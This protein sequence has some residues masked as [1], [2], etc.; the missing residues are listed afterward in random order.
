MRTIRSSLLVL[1]FA[2]LASCA[3]HKPAVESVT[4]PAATSSS[5]IGLPSWNDTPTKHAI[6]DYVAR[7]TRLGSSEYVSP[8]ARI[9]VFDN[10]GTLWLEQPAYTQLVFIFQRVH[11]L[12]P[13]HPEWNTEELFRSILKGDM[14]GVAA[15]GE[16]GLTKLLAATHAGMSTDAF[17]QIVHNWF[18]TAKDR[19][20]DRLYTE[21]AYQPMIEVLRYLEANGFTN[22]IVTGG[23]VEFVRAISQSVYAIPPEHVIGSTVKYKY[24]IMD[25][26]PTLLRLAQIANINDG[27]GKPQTIEA[28]IG[29][30]PLMAFGNS[31]GDQQMLEWT[32]AGSGARFAALVHHT[33]GE[34]EYAYDKA[35]KVGKLDKALDEANSKRW[36]V[37]DM[38]KDWNTMFV[39]VSAQPTQPTQPAQTK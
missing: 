36:T 17:A 18:E 9:A 11:V 31:D 24:S 2:I 1:G 6:V 20:F 33:D 7:V 3:D 10:D 25:G 15:T 13:V 39:P 27:P 12:A 4:V 19:R 28:V 32:A 23:G 8:E 29:R 34:R 16:E 35:S 14:N 5:G 26:V 38:Q 21:L 30:R 37:I 22:Y